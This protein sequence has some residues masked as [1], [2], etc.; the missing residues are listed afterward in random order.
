MYQ[1]DFK[2]VT[3]HPVLEKH[4]ELLQELNDDRVMCICYQENK[5]GKEFYIEE[6]CDE[7]FHHTLTKEEC[8]ELSELFKEIA[9]SI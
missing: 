4:I 5:E 9:D 1:G 7:W 8:I 6:Q 3:R 2:F